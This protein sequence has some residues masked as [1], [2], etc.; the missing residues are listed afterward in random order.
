MQSITTEWTIFLCAVLNRLDERLFAASETS[1]IREHL[2]TYADDIIA[3]WTIDSKDQIY[4][5]ICQIGQLLD[6]LQEV[7]MKVNFAKTAFLMRLSGYQAR[8]IRKQIFVK[9]DSKLWLRIPRT[10]SPDALI[11][12]KQQHP[13]LG[14]IAS[15]YA[16]EDST[17]THRL[18]IGCVTFLRL[19]AWLLKRH[20]YPIALRLRLWQTC[21][22]SSYVYG[23]QAVGMTAKGALP[24]HQ[25]FVA[26]IR[27]IARSPSHITFESTNALFARLNLD[28]PWKV[29]KLSGRSSMTTD[30]PSGNA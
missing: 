17:L 24:L 16:F 28:L 21:V 9:S 13:Y 3:K 6:A 23:L 8:G 1:W 14:V 7:G 26:D 11:P 20:T 4:Q 29:F 25:H 15:F 10:N 19:R 12:V 5:M 30:V 2:I 18:H 22:K 27:S